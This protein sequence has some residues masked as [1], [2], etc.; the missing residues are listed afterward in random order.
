MSIKKILFIVLVFFAAL[1]SF[2]LIWIHFYATPDHPL[3][4]QGKLDLRDW[5]SISEYPITLDG[6]W[7]FFPGVF[8][9][10]KNKSIL[11][12]EFI[13]VPGSWEVSSQS[14]N[15]YGIG[16][17]RLRILV[18]PTKG[19]KYGIRIPYISSSSKIYVNGTLL[20]GSGE[21]G[22]SK[23]DY[24]PS[25]KPYTVYFPLENKSEI[26]LV[27]QVANFDNAGKGGIVRSLEFG[28]ED[29]LRK[30]ITSKNTIILIAGAI[31][32]IH[33]LYSFILFLVGNR[34][35]RL[36]YF[37]L[38]IICLVLGTLIGERLLFEWFPLN[39]EWGIKV[40]YLTIIAGGF[41]LLQ[42]IKQQLSNYFRTKW[43][44][45]YNILCAFL[46]LTI[47]LLSAEDNLKF[48][49][50]YIMV[51]LI[52]C[53][54]ALF[55][56]YD[57]TRKIDKEN[58]FLLLALVAAVSS[59]MWLIIL[60]L[61]QNEVGPYPFDLLI[62]TI[63]FAIYWFKQYFQL[64]DE[65]QKLTRKLQLED[66]RKDEFLQS[67]AHEMRNPLHGIL[68]ISQ[69]VT[70]REKDALDRKSVQDLELLNTVG[71]RMTF[72]LND[73]LEIERFKENK[74]AIEP[75][76]IS[77]YNVT[78]SVM[79]MLRFMIDE[80]PINLVNQI[81][82]HFPH[83]MADENRMNQILFNLLHNAIKNTNKGEISVQASIQDE[84]AS[85]SVQD[86]GKG[87]D[88]KL[89]NEIFK[90]YTRN[91]EEIDG[92]F[93]L[94]LSISKQ[95]IEL[96]GGDIRVNSELG[97]GTIFTFTLKLSVPSSQR[98]GI[99]RS[100][101]IFQN[102]SIVSEELASSTEY[103][104]NTSTIGDYS[105]SQHPPIRI[106]IIDDD[107]INLK[108]MERIFE[109]DRY[110]VH[111]TTSSHQAL[112]MLRDQEWDLM[113]TDV[114]MPEMSGFELTSYVRK[115][116]SVLE[117]PVLLLTAYNRPEDIEL[118]FEAGAND[119]VTKPVSASELRAR[120]QSLT[121]IKKT[122]GER[123]RMEAAWL[124]A[125]IKP[126]F[127]IN[128]FNSIA[129]LSR[130][131]L[132]RMD[133]LLYE[134]SNFIRLSIHFQNTDGLSPLENELQLVHSYL[135]I[136]QERFSDRIQIVWEIDKEIDINIPPL[137]IQPLVENSIH[138]GILKRREGGMVRISVKDFEEIAVI[139]VADNGVGMKDELIDQL[140]SGNVDK[141]SGIGILNIDQRLK[142]LYGQGL[143]V[144]SKL[145]EGTIISFTVKK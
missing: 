117:L 59:L 115:Q 56:M 133:K 47:L 33:A 89:L 28:L 12:H 9:S 38:T 34:D 95:L 11:T 141:H 16:S 10:E 139:S 70:Q 97:K 1:T 75:T 31:Y 4:V 103:E 114:M 82:K 35:K 17:Y 66:K 30:S 49:L 76:D 55:L 50:G 104:N 90:P 61:F 145:D 60:T 110:L 14:P 100:S 77:I 19:N 84:W 87:I 74:I 27:I 111:T 134:F 128:T 7:D 18:D 68:N 29:P 80:K 65:S 96:H 46:A 121:N 124:Q 13:Q 142:H 23:Q 140:L 15:T 67:V 88:E 102:K 25:N 72:L 106:L 101:T 79:N 105:N 3:A 99:P 123:L 73:L 83:V 53:F 42:C 45:L 135:F 57:I 98:E 136:Q 85:I 78:E 137:S 81:P 32:I 91:V 113:I 118:G 6:E 86:T 116:F 26:T 120:V 51:M 21:V 129:A 58:I 48:T 44:S 109:V 54:L 71:R 52:P 39:F 119:Y 36:F 24:I 64:L 63:C 93:G 8:L 107:P 132:D 92:G 125:Q 108:V 143:K 127:I 22:H 130:L 43:F 20:S 131:D 41:F 40:K 69:A 138:H 37:S 112:S 144:E 2:R 94:G 122:M 5:D 126:H 62:A